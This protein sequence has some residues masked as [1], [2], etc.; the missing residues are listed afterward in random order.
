MA[1]TTAELVIKILDPGG[2][3]RCGTDLT[4][5]IRAANRIVTRVA[6]CATDGGDSLDSETLQD[7]ESWLAAHYYTRSDPTYKSRSTLRASGEMNAD[8]SEFLTAALSLDPS[9]CLAEIMNTTE[10]KV[11]SVK[12]TGKKYNNQRT[13]W[14]R[15]G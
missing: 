9:G 3:Y 8:G 4:F 10:S 13:Y 12:W 15:N 11:A 1:R 14:G 2:N 6:E 7:I 5:A